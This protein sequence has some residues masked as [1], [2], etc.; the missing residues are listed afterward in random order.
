MF[1][2]AFC[3]IPLAL[4]A[5]SVVGCGSSD[6][7]TTGRKLTANSDPAHPEFR[8]FPSEIYSGFNASVSF[9]M[10][11]IPVNN[12]SDTVTW[13]VAD[14]SIAIS[15]A[16][17]RGKITLKAVKA[18]ETKLTAT[19]GTETATAKVHVIAYTDAQIQAGERRWFA[20]SS[21]GTTCEQCHGA[22]TKLNNTPVELDADTDDDIKV[23]FVDG[24]DPEGRE[25][26]SSVMPHKY[27]MTDDEAIGI[28]A[29]MRALT[30]KEK[31]DGA[32]PYPDHEEFCEDCE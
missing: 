25:I 32:Y 29:Y 8:I 2:P 23:T 30:P 28:I 5:V 10:P 9:L 11:V 14:T 1:R 22:S 27:A 6:S 13:K 31:N 16:E 26:E 7:G 18:G 17:E 4:V 15:S 19:S 20:E 21:D 3:V 12:Q 24:V